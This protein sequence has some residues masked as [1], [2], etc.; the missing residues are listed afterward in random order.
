MPIVLSRLVPA[1]FFGLFFYVGY[2]V[3]TTHHVPELPV[4]SLDTWQKSDAPYGIP[5]TPDNPNETQKFDPRMHLHS[6]FEAAL[7]PTAPRFDA[8]MGSEHAALTYNAQGFMEAN[9]TRGGQHTGDDINGIGGQDTDYG[10]AVYA[11]ANG[12]V[13]Y[14]G[15]PSAGWGKTIILAHRLPDGR[16]LH[17]MYAHLHQIEVALN[18]YA[19]RGAQIG[20]VG[21][22]NGRYLAHLH[23][24]M[25]E[26]D[27]FSPQAGYSSHAFDRLDPEATIEA[28]RGAANNQLNPS[29]LTVL[30]Q[31]RRSK[32]RLPEMD[33]ESALKLQEFLHRS[34]K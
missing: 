28:N 3:M 29:A 26:T 16:T 6:P 9:S 8:A 23:L 33:A 27:G 14:A 19:G 7:I 4:Q 11:V 13:V 1:L 34:S 24:E 22:A 31:S 10:D 21:N 18:S 17:S 25:R 12:L 2:L 20:S 32:N 30:Q 5:L 15:T